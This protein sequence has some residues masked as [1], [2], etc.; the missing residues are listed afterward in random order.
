MARI[1]GTQ[2]NVGIGI[3]A[4][5]GTAVAATYFP[6]W[7][8]LSL[9]GVSEKSMFE[10][11]RGVRNMSSN[12]MIKRRYSKGA[13][14]VVPTVK[15]APL[16]FYLALGSKSTA[17]PSDSAYTHTFTVQ[18]ANASMKTATII[19]ER[20]GEVTERFAG[21]VVSQLTLDVS[22]DYGKLSANIIGGF[23]DTSTLTESYAT[24]TEFAY[25]QLVVKFGDNLTDA[26]SAS[27]TP[28]KAFNL[29]I[30]NQVDEDNAYLF[31]ANTPTA[32]GFSAGR[33]K[34]TGSYTL[35]MNGTGEIDAYKVNTK[36][37]LIATFTG[38]LIGTSSLESITINLGRLVLTGNPIQVNL[39]GLTMIQQSFQVEYD[40]TDKECSVV[41]V[42]NVASYA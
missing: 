28:L 38:A 10:G 6:N 26:A 34:I 33:L 42:N 35:P 25:H 3:E 1:G 13:I 23:P 32:G 7:T 27:A 12:S 4:T 19:V 20:G 31:G 37:A 8:E 17:G 29:V 41:V 36:N 21:C 9:Q 14:S 5:A 30:D 15:I 39:N 22:D 16:L 2:I 11:Q 40:A 18:N 24:E